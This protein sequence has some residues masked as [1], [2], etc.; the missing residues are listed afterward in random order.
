MSLNTFCLSTE[1]WKRLMTNR[2]VEGDVCI[3]RVVCECKRPA[4]LQSPHRRELSCIY[5]WHLGYYSWQQGCGS[6]RSIDVQEVQ[7]VVVFFYIVLWWIWFLFQLLQKVLVPCGN[8]FVSA[9]IDSR[10]VRRNGHACT[11]LLPAKKT[12]RKVKVLIQLFYLIK[13]EKVQALKCTLTKRVKSNKDNSTR[14]LNAKL[15]YPHN[16]ISKLS[17]PFWF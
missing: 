10:N 16:V 2:V 7:S 14:C 4:Q 1:T 15:F 13:R 3:T 9:L 6:S 12:F 5:T 8:P 17:N 11:V